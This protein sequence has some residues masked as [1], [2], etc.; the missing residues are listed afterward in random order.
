MAKSKII[1]DIGN[2]VVSLETSLKRALIIASDIGN[3]KLIDWL[4]HELYGYSNKESLPEY[5]KF[6]G[7]IFISYFGGRVRMENQVISLNNFD[8]SVWKNIQYKCTEGIKTIQDL[9]EG[10]SSPA[11]NL[12]DYQHYLKGCDYVEVTDV[13]MDLT[14][15]SFQKILDTVSMQLLDILIKLDKELGNLDDLDVTVDDSKKDK[16]DKMINLFADSI[17][18]IGDNN[19]IERTK[20]NGK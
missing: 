2:N 1:K 4:K 20:I 8:S 15:Y 9:A 17:T 12:F 16:I 14:P 11:I 6:Y 3:E 10:K 19:E 18:I 7:P 5:R 13:H